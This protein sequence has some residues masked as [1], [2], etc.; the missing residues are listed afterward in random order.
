MSNCSTFCRNFSTLRCCEED[1]KSDRM[2]QYFKT[3]PKKGDAWTT[4]STTERRPSKLKFRGQFVDQ[5]S[6]GERTGEEDTRQKITGVDGSR[7]GK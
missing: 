7:K 3:N 2:R 1:Q 6:I 4:P 5:F